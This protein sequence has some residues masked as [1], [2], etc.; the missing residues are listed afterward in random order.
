MA[1]SLLVELIPLWILLGLVVLFATFVLL[2]RV[3]GG[4]YVRPIVAA[5]AK[6]PLFKR[7]MTK[8][9][10]AA[11]ERQN[12]ELASAVKKLQRFGNLSDPRQA[13]KAL[14]ALTAGE[15]RA[16]LAATGEQQEAEPQPLNR[17]QRRRLEKA[18]R[19][20]RK[21]RA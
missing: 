14:S 16:Y 5:V 19:E 9:S 20:A 8:A 7:L 18:Q 15:R 4:R 1:T 6:V 10:E 12:P 21:P 3:R 17:E 11:L 2:A 13:Q